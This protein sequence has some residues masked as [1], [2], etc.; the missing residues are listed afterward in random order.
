SGAGGLGGV[1]G[2]GDGAVPGAWGTYVGPILGTQT[3]ANS[4][5]GANSMFGWGG[6]EAATTASAAGK[7]AGGFGAGG[8]GAAANN[9]TTPQIGGAGAPGLVIVTEYGLTALGSATNAAGAVRFDLPQS[10]T[11]TQKAQGRA[12]I[13]CL[14]KNYIINGAMQ[15]SQEWGNTALG[16][17]GAMS[18]YVADQWW[19]VNTLTGTCT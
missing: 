1:A 13:D 5:N 11:A 17:T 18:S 4:G 9:N 7:P 2:T 14:K 15:I 19:G 8:S 16:P 6:P 10:L 3:A 12:N